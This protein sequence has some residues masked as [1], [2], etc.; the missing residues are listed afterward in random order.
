[1]QRAL[2]LLSRYAAFHR[3]RRN[4]VTHI[5]GIPLA[6]FG[7]GVLLSRPALAAGDLALTPAWLCWGAAAVWYLSRGDVVLGAVVSA[8]SALLLVLATPLGRLSTSLWLA[9]GFGTL[10]LGWALQ[11]VGHWYEGRRPAMIDGLRGLLVGPLFVTAEAL[12]ALGWG[13]RLLSEIERRVG[14]THVRDL[15]AMRS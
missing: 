9:W 11:M 12:F 8:A 3:D 6:V 5:V 1:M 2:D 13:K 14:P 10:M 15:A 4:I 7:I